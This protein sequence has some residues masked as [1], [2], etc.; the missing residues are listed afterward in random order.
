MNVDAA[1]VSVDGIGLGMARRQ[2]PLFLSNLKTGM[3]RIRVE[4]D[5]YEPQERRVNI[6][7]E[8]VDSGR[9]CSNRTLRSREDAYPS[10]AIGHPGS[11]ARG[12]LCW[13]LLA[14]H[15]EVVE[16]CCV[17]NP[18]FASMSP[19][20]EPPIFWY[21][22]MRA[23]V[24]HLTPS[25]LIRPVYLLPCRWS[26]RYQISGRC[27]KMHKLP[28]AKLTQFRLDIGSLAHRRPW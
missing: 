9:I 14:L 20:T 7:G 6:G 15:H 21:K 18:I 27:R 1:R 10:L 8:R 19:E 13:S 4:A 22:H 3:V 2:A 12:T 5:G 24:H 17:L 11:P 23:K 26:W 25:T 28:I 16:L